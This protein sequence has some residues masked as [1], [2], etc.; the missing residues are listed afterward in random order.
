VDAKR[1]SQIPIKPQIALCVEDKSL[2]SYFFNCKTGPN[3]K[4]LVTKRL[5]DYK[6]ETTGAVTGA[7]EAFGFKDV[8]EVLWGDDK[9]YNTNLF[10]IFCL[11]IKDILSSD[12]ENKGIIENTLCDNIIYS[13]Y[14]TFRKI[15]DDYNISLLTNYGIFD[16]KVEDQAMNNYLKI[17][18]KHLY[19]KDGFEESFK[20]IFKSFTNRF[21]DYTHIEDRL[22]KFFLPDLLSLLEKYMPS[23]SSLGLRVKTLIETDIIKAKD[24]IQAHNSKSDYC[25]TVEYHLNQKII[26]ATSE[27]ITKLEEI[28]ELS[29]ADGTY[30]YGW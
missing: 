27:Y 24:L 29:Y 30:I 11:L 10:S 1:K 3:N 21:N 7:K 23:S 8:H 20:N 4:Y 19:Y 16:E 22:Y 5:L 28:A 15:K 17:A 25:N 12:Y 18:I 6:S 13:K 9:E 14:S 2:V 26:R